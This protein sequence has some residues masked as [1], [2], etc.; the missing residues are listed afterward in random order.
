MQGMAF[1]RGFNIA[2][3]SSSTSLLQ[4]CHV[5]VAK[6]LDQ[7]RWSPAIHAAFF[8]VTSRNIKTR[9]TATSNHRLC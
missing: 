7:G 4:P 2:A 1:R 6:V 8:R 5:V 9:L 3:Q